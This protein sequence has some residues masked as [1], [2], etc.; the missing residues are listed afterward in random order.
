M[1]RCILFR[2]SIITNVVSI[3]MEANIWYS[4]KCS[5]YWM[6]QRRLTLSYPMLTQ[7]DNIN[8][9]I[10]N[11]FMKK[12]KQRLHEKKKIVWAPLTR[13][14][15]SGCSGVMMT[16]RRT[17]VSAIITYEKQRRKK[18]WTRKN[19]N[20]KCFVKIVNTSKKNSTHVVINNYN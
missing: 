16:V 12:P 14:F 5:S 13:T 18:N 6:S 4:F 2:I 7:V 11:I 19:R 9:E 1:N 20:L 10:S 17:T 15:T 8:N 3:S